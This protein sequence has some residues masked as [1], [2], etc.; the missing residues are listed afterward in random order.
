ML[1]IYTMNTSKDDNVKV[2]YYARLG[3]KV[4]KKTK[5]STIHIQAS[6]NTPVVSRMSLYSTLYIM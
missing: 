6:K 2:K 4:K 3:L 1:Y 5:R